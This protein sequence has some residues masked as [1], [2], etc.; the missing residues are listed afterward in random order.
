AITFICVPNKYGCQFEEPVPPESAGGWAPADSS[1]GPIIRMPQAS[2][3]TIEMP[4]IRIRTWR[5]PPRTSPMSSTQR[6]IA[7]VGNSAGLASAYGPMPLSE[8][9]GEEMEREG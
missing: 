2:V 4:E 6:Q 7:R 5:S 1:G 8:C 9:R 3:R